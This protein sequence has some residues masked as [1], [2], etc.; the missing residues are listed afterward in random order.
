MAT[1]IE[2]LTQDTFAEFLKKGT[3]LVDFWATWCGPCRMQGQI[4]AE[5][6]EEDSFQGN[7]GKLDV[8]EARDIAVKYNIMSIPTIIIFKNGE[9]DKV[10]VGLQ[11]SE[12]IK[13]ALK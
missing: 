1:K 12:V 2:H 8:D 5:L 6:A 7:I 10:L 13:E 4:L 3:V 11:D 9:P